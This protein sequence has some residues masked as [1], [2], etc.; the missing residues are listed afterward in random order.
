MNHPIDPLIIIGTDIA[1]SKDANNPAVDPPIVLT[2]AKITIV[3]NAQIIPGNKI[4][5]LYHSILLSQL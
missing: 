3:V 2:S 1:Q 4:V 5:I